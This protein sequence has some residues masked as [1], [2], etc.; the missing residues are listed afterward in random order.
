MPVTGTPQEKIRQ[1]MH[2]FKH[3]QLHSG[4][5]TGP[6][7]KNRD[8]AIAIAMSV[9]R[10]RAAGGA[11]GAPPWYIR[12][13]ARGMLHTGPIRSPVAGRTDHLALNVP[14]GSYVLPADHVSHLG[15][16][17]TQ[18][19]HSLLNGMFS[20]GPF[21]TGLPKMGRGSGMPKGGGKPPRSAFDDGGAVFPM[22]EGGVPYDGGEAVP[23]MAAGGEYILPP[24]IVRLMPTLIGEPPSLHQGH[25]LLDAWVLSER[26]KHKA[27]LAKLPGPAK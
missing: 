12:N 26:K 16:N 8:Q 10:K 20:S 27:T 7:V 19:G 13:E 23:I 25:Q 18:A 24:H 22:A 1:E 11:S 6:I 17:N 15:Q 4:S 9:A 21:G 5:E 3:H 14:A 2:R